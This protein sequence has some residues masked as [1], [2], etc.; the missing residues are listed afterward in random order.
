VLKTITA[1]SLGLLLCASTAVA[2]LSS[3]QAKR[4]SA[5][6][7]VVR[8][9]RD[10][11]DQGIPEY[12]WSRAECVA[13][14]PGLKKAAFI[15]GGEFGKGVISC[16]SGQSWSAPIFFE[17]E[18]GSAGFQIGAEDIDLVLLM[19]NRRGVNK[20][21]EDKMTLGA[22]AS[23]AAGPVGRV[24]SVGTDAR[25]AAE[26]LAYSRAQGVFAGI[27]L[28]GGV[29]RADKDANRAAYGPSVAGR[30]VLLRND[31]KAPAEAQ[32]FLRTLGEES[33]AT[34]GRR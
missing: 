14:I 6:A 8:E 34:S 12:L 25:L 2:D 19:M 7:S 21:L 31:V 30:E 11:P 26:L 15:V 20:L 17:L 13:V 16:R 24:A 28:S 22:D 33:R 23:I 9:I 4:L 1:L 3:S 29:L 27:N 18:K 5:A 32:A 10:V